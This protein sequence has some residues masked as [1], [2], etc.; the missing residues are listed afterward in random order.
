MPVYITPVPDGPINRTNG[1]KLY[2]RYPAQPS[3][4]GFEVQ[5]EAGRRFVSKDGSGGAH[6]QL[7]TAL[8]VWPYETVQ[9][10]GHFILEEEI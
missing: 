1:F 4:F 2:R 9:T 5:T 8:K 10:A 3:G 6:L 7:V